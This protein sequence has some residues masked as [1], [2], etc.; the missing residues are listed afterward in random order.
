MKTI[1]LKPA[2]VSL[3]YLKEWQVD[4]YPDFKQ[5]YVNGKKVSDTLY[6]IGGFSTDLKKPYFM[7]LKYVKDHYNE[8]ILK[9]YKNKN[10]KHLAGHWC[11]IDNN[12]KEK[13]I[14]KQFAHSYL[15]GGMIYFLEGK[16]Y[17]IETGELYCASNNCI[18]SKEYLFLENKYDEDISRRG[19]FQIKKSDGTYII[20]K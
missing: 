4:H 11:I 10:P 18:K 9:H 6:R 1:E 14:F 16:Y 13:Q 20:I 17:N 12:G 15:P 5:L 3:D 7:L 8:D 2:N 19:V